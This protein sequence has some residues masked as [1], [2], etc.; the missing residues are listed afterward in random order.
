MKGYISIFVCVKMLAYD[1]MHSSIAS[2]TKHVLIFSI[3]AALATINYI[4]LILVES[5]FFRPI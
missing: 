5:A 1:Y 3:V 4:T 2:S